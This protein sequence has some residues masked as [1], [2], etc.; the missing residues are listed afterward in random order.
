MKIVLDTN[1]L[2]SGLMTKGGTCATILDLLSD[3]RI[4][5][6]LDGRIMHEYRRVCVEPRLRL[7]VSAVTDFLRFL[8]DC[9]ENVTAMPLDANL[10]DPDDLPFLEVAADA[11]AILVT[12]NIRHFPKDS[13][14][15]VQVVTPQEFLD[16]LRS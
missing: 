16:L 8:D 14:G 12:G 15:S 7:D 4:T 10:P 11:R 3:G 9:A 1:V 6:A 13:I 5:A 2:V